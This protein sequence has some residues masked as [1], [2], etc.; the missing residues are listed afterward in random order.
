MSAIDKDVHRPWLAYALEESLEHA[1]LTPKDVVDHAN[2]E[3]LVNQ[4]PPPVISVLLSRALSIGTFSAA[5]VLESV[6]P[7]LLAEHLDPGVMWRCLEV[8]AERGGLS[9]PGG[10][11]STRARQWFAS[12]VG[13]ALESALV[14]PADVLRFLPPSEFAAGA[15]RSVMAEL[16]REALARSRFDPELVLQHITPTVMA[17]NLET[18]LVWACVSEAAAHHFGLGAAP[19]RPVVP[20]SAKPALP[21][22]STPAVPAAVTGKSVQRPS[23][24]SGEKPER[25]PNGV[26][27]GKTPSP[28]FVGGEALA[29]KSSSGGRGSVGGDVAAARTPAIAVPSPVPSTP[30]GRQESDDWT[31]AADDHR[32]PF[33]PR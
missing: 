11:R 7:A 8:A 4:L 22:V 29:N 23:D 14:T 5:Q 26:N 10:S 30:T 32:F 20:S 31:P 3:V 13:R 16:L 27:D 18:S 12:I 25:G 28:V 6:P 2:P 15:P 21:S 1:L 19:T 17:E 9:Q 24:R 33:P